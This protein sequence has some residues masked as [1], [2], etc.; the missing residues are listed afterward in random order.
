MIQAKKPR[1]EAVGHSWMPGYKKRLYAASDSYDGLVSQMS[2]LSLDARY[3][4]K[5][6][7][8]GLTVETE[9]YT[10]DLIWPR[11]DWEITKNVVTEVTA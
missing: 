5:G 9:P 7:N 4:T 6:M 2:K 1:Y 8:G 3:T 11:I 10:L